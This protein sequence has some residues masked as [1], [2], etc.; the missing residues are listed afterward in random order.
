M[1]VMRS[2]VLLLVLVLIPALMASQVNLNIIMPDKYLREL[3]DLSVLGKELW[4][5]PLT[6]SVLKAYE[7]EMLRGALAQFNKT[8]VNDYLQFAKY[9]MESYKLMSGRVLPPPVQVTQAKLILG[10]AQAYLRAIQADVAALE[11]VTQSF[12]FPECQTNATE[13]TLMKLANVTALSPEE[14]IEMVN[15]LKPGKVNPADCYFMM[16]LHEILTGLKKWISLKKMQLK[17]L[18][19]RVNIYNR[20]IDG[21]IADMYAEKAATVLQSLADDLKIYTIA[22]ILNDSLPVIASP[23]GDVQSMAY[24]VGKNMYS[25][26]RYGFMISVASPYAQEIQVPEDCQGVFNTMSNFLVTLNVNMVNAKYGGLN[27]L[28]SC[29]SIMLKSELN[30][31]LKKHNENFSKLEDQVLQQE[32]NLEKV[33]NAYKA[34]ICSG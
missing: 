4:G 32:A 20:V 29:F 26:T 11:N 12:D 5:T 15:S 2:A 3:S 33:V 1:E 23:E 14:A 19:T 18:E 24:T 16:R 21:I 30:M 28:A 34:L 7:G 31:S 8:I 27:K 17:E 25:V 6:C 22:K 10:S 9:M 13:D